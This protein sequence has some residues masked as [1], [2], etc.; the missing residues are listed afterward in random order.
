MTAPGGKGFLYN[1]K[2]EIAATGQWNHVGP[3]RTRRGKEKQS[4]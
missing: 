1:I 2:E 3:R 4:L